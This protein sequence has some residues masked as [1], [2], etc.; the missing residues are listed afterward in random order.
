MERCCRLKSRCYISD[1]SSFEKLLKG[2]CNSPQITTLNHLFLL[3]SFGGLLIFC[4]LQTFPPEFKM[5]WEHFSQLR[6][7][8]KLDATNIHLNPFWPQFGIELDI[9][10][11]CAALI[12]C[13][14]CQL[15]HLDQGRVN[16]P[17][18][19]LGGSW[20]LSC[21]ILQ[22]CQNFFELF[23]QQT[24]NQEQFLVHLFQTAKITSF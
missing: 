11:L 10:L 24:S 3:A 18:R 19:D 22:L 14:L 6:S 12:L 8:L 21:V 20:F 4:F 1:M 15:F 23:V 9:W 2:F 5:K 7:S 17:S 16:F 13:Q